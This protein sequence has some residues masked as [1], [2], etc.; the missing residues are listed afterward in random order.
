[1]TAKPLLVAIPA[2]CCDGD[3]YAA[4]AEGLADLV[5]LRTIIPVARTLTGCVQRVLN[6]IDEPAF[7]VG[8]SFGGHVARE[9]ALLAPQRMRGVWVMGAGAGAPADPTSGIARGK[10]LR[11]GREEEVYQ[12]FARMVTHLSGPRG[13]EAADAFL[14][15]ARRCDPLKVAV[16]NDA[17]LVR[18]DRWNDLARIAA[19]ALL[20]WGVH[21]RFS[22]PADGL[23]MAGLMP[24]ARFVQVPDCGHL[25]SLEAPEETIAVARH[26]LMSILA[27]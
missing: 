1:M 22:P 14:A 15:M 13:K 7:V 8:T 17:L 24:N 5:S 20:L 12:N 2:L 19:P 9:M 18:P 26:W 10:L 27:G 3:L 11:S 23:R 16:Q 21:D 25:P 4:M 6:E